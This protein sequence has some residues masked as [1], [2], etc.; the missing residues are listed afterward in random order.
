MS[1]RPAFSFFAFILRDGIL[2]L[3]LR[4]VRNDLGSVLNFISVCRLG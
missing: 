2:D 4:V 3:T 1:Q